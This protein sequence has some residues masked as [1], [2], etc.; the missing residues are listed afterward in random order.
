M[1]HLENGTVKYVGYQEDSLQTMINGNL[2]NARFN[3]TVGVEAERATKTM[4]LAVL[5]V[6]VQKGSRWL[7]FARQAVKNLKARAC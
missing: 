5:E 1:S 4:N 3:A 7:L 2:A 6:W